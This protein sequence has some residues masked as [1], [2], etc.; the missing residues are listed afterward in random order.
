M[1][2]IERRIADWRRA[3]AE[4]AG[5][6]DEVLDELESHLRD[7][8]QR[9]VLTGEPE[10][11]ALDLALSR[12]GPPQALAAVFAKLARDGAATWLPVRLANGV[13]LALAAALVGYCAGRLQDGRLGLLLASHVVAVTLGYGTT[14]LV[15]GLAFCYVATR[16]YHPPRPA[17]IGALT[18]AVLVMTWLA[19]AATTLG[20]FLGGVWAKDN[21]GRFWGWDLKETGG[22]IVLAW[23]AI[24]ILFCW[25]RPAA[26]HAAMLLAFAG[27][28]VVAA[29][30]FGPGLLAVGLHVYGPPVLTVT[31]IGFV[32]LAHVAMLALG[33]APAGWL[34]RAAMSER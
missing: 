20:V 2:D 4:T 32:T 25:R 1:P 22:A 15:G 9:L 34:R 31:V 17:Q 29:A 13:L 12:L 11:R 30:W 33:L 24:M 19:L 14:L 18:R 23:D 7:D 3:L 10:E 28:V 8:V 26:T 16:S 6:T 5:C 27:N 21:L